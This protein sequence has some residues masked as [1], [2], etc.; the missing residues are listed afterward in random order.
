MKK[1]FFALPLAAL[2]AAGCNSTQQSINQ[3]PVPSPVVQNKKPAA[4]PTSTQPQD[5]TL[6]GRQNYNSPALGLKF[7]YWQDGNVKIS[8]Q[9]NKITISDKS[10]PGDIGQT[11]EM[12]PK[13]P[14]DTL[15]QAIQKL[16]L[17]D[18][19]ASKCFVKTLKSSDSY[20]PPAFS[21][22][23]I[24][25]YPV[26]EQGDPNRPWFSYG[27]NCPQNYKDG[28]SNGRF[29]Y[30][31]NYTDK[32]YFLTFGQSAWPFLN[33]PASGNTGDWR[34]TIQIVPISK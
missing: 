12:F 22:E 29:F 5:T 25:S 15:T 31:A 34:T 11:I 32:F 18:I 30:N 17:K 2:L 7:S 21:E 28:Q 24:I 10:V 3:A 1:L 19:P 4:A 23:A 14:S 20:L 13:N 8:E 9:Q 27:D 26:P 33:D 16:F 6:I